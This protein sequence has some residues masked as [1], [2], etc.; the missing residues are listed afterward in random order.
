MNKTVKED[1]LKKDENIDKK[2]EARLK[3]KELISKN[4]DKVEDVVRKKEKEKDVEKEK[5]LRSIIQSKKSQDRE[6]K[7]LQAE[8]EREKKQREY[9]SDGD[10]HCGDPDCRYI[11]FKKNSVC[12]MCDKPPPVAPVFWDVTD[13]DRPK[14]K[15]K[16]KKSKK[17]YFLF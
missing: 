2:E 10:W 17:V 11:N 7:E 3:L 14:K 5:D 15:T 6:K 8:L 16:S 9:E 12:K 1:E 13:P 4:R